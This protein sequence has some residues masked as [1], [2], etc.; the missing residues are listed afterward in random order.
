[1][2][3]D[4]ISLAALIVSLN[5]LFISG[6]SLGW[7]IYKELV[8][9]ARARVEFS[10]VR[11]LQNMTE[12]EQML[13]ISIVN[14]GPG[15]VIFEMIL[16]KNQ[17]YGADFGEVVPL[18]MSFPATIS[19]TAR[20]CQKHLLL[21][22]EQRSLFPTMKTACSRS[23]PRT[24]VSVTRTEERIGPQPR[25]SR[26]PAIAIGGTSATSQ[27]DHIK[28]ITAKVAYGR[29]LISD[30]IFRIPPHFSERCLKGAEKQS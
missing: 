9:K 8:P 5:S 30:W 21:E 23:G 26:R 22:S 24:S 4:A 7:N 1:M 20:A 11:L 15:Q 12:G 17:P 6:L 10:I 18:T 3:K 25:W 16:I 27:K 19:N 2:N 29:R 13:D 14:H 28:H